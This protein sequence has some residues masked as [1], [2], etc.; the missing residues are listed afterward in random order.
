[1]RNQTALTLLVSLVTATA[2]GAQPGPALMPVPQKMECREG[3]FVLTP[4]TRI[5]VNRAS[6]D[7]GQFLADALRKATGYQLMQISSAHPRS[8]RGAITLTT[9]DANAALGPEGYEL[10]VA[11]DSVVIRAPAAAGLFYG[12]QTLLQLLP[13]ETCATNRAKAAAC[14]IPCVQIQDQPRFKWR[15]FMLDVARHF[16]TK[17]EVK[18]LLDEMAAQKLNRFH[19]H[20]TDDQGWRIE[21]KSYPRLTQVGAWREEAGFDLDPKLSTNYRA[22]GKYG[23]YYTKADLRDIVAYAAARHITVV[24]EIEM[25]G[26]SCAA[27][28]AYPELS[29]TGGPYTP[30]TKGGVFAGVYCAG[31]DETFDFLQNVLAEVMEIF[32][33]PYIHIGGDEVPKDNWKKCP[34]CQDRMKQEGLKTEHELQSYFIRRI[35]KFINSK[36]RTL[37]GWSEIREGG[38]AQNAVVMDWIG[39]AVEA[40]GAGHDVVM[41]PTKFCYLDYYQST[42]HDAEPKAIGGYLPLSKVYSFDPMP[43]GL[44]AQHQSHILGGQGNL[45]TEYV[46]NFK[47]AQYMIFPRLCAIAEVTWSPASS[48]NW[49]DFTRRLQTQFQRFD[50]QGVN[51]RKGTPGQI[52]E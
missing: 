18:Q 38:L 3:A 28:A 41:S 19:L 26:H 12:V 14:Q 4:K 39:G 46:P 10:T 24:P 32:P 49:E 20:L 31:K 33:G 1:M 25:P 30:N 5:E 6:Q 22:D 7:T 37:I 36:G 17:A 47:H 34:R 50:A 23:G 27:L 21:I 16:F 44:D 48:H 51:Y 35:E 52:G 29:C 45:W 43:A 42:N 8:P 15:G 11:P 13:P 2:F 9:N 40:A